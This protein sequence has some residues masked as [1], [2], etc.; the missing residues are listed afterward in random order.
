MMRSARKSNGQASGK[1]QLLTLALL[2]GGTATVLGS[3][4]AAWA[5]DRAPTELKMILSPGKGNSDVI[6]FSADG[7]EKAEAVEQAATPTA[8]SAKQAAPTPMTVLPPESTAE[9]AAERAELV[10][11]KSSPRSLAFANSFSLGVGYRWDSVFFNIATLSRTPNILSELEYD[12]FESMTL[13]ANMRWSNSSNV[14]VRGGVDI[15]RTIT[16]DVRDS[17][18]LGNNRT[19]EFSRSYADGDGGSLVDADVGAGYRFDLPFSGRDRYMRL[20]PLV[21]YSYHSQE[22][23]MTDGVQAIAGYGFD[24]PLGPFDGLDSNYDAHWAGPWIGLDMELAFNLRHALL[25]SLEYHW[26]DYEADADWNLRSDFAHPISFEHDSNGDGVVA[27]ITYRYTPNPKWFWTVG[28]KFS[29]FDADAG[30]YT[31]YRSDDTVSYARFN[32]AEWESH[33]VMVGLGFKF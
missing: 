9:S 23:E 25:A 1:K 20:M 17:D 31:V 33:A 30:E 21:G 11:G 16:G 13:S 15:G 4:A 32:E 3:G 12:D 2:L 14:Y 7:E 26:V 29:K 27:A 18:Y 5:A 8:A 10:S 19:M 22:L 6:T 24:V 28:Y